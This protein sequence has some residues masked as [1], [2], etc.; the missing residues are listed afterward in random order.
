[1][2]LGCAIITTPGFTQDTQVDSLLAIL[3]ISVDDTSKVNTLND[4][5]SE[6]YRNEPEEAVKYGNMAK[7]L[8]EKLDF[9]KGLARALN[10]IGLG[11]YMQ[12]NYVEASINWAESL[13]IYESIQDQIG[14]TAMLSNLGAVFSMQGD[15]AKAIEYIL[16]SLKISEDSGDSL[17]MATCLLNI[18]AIYSF[19][20]ETRDKALPYYI[21]ALTMCESIN[22]MDGIALSASNL[23][24]YY[25][26]K[27]VYDS[28]LLYLEKSIDVTENEIDK[29]S[30]LDNI[31]KVYADKGDFQSALKYQKEGYEIAEN[32]NAK[33]EMT[34]SLVS[35]GSTY[36]QMGNFEM[37]IKYYQKALT[38][39]IE[40]G[41]NYE[42]MYAY[43]GLALSYSSLSDFRS[44]YK[45]QKLLSSI[46]DSIYNV[47][48]DDKIKSLQ[49]TYQLE[50]KEDEIEILEKNSEIEQLKTK[51]QRIVSL[52][53]GSVG[54]LLLVLAIVIY[55]RFIFTR[56]TKKIIEK[57]R[58]RSDELLL[59]IL[60]SETAE[61]L[62]MNGE[63]KAKSY[64][65]VTVLFTDFKGFTSIAAKMSPEELVEEVNNCY[66]QFDYIITK[67]GIEKI[68]TIGDAYMAAGGLP[69]PNE[70]HA[71]DVLNA[72]IEINDYMLKLKSERE[73]ENRLFF[74]I[75]IGI[76]SGPVVAGIVGIKK[77]AYD[78]WGDTV[79]IAARMETNS[80][81]SKIN[82]SETTYKLVKNYFE[83]SYR[84]EIEAKNRGK[85]KMYY[86]EDKIDV[87]PEVLSDIIS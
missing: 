2:F 19:K 87:K 9:Q 28:A 22:Y 84:G 45:Y 17:R 56:R 31:G 15:E 39:G 66:Q 69:V 47:E 16:R 80:E 58:D 54:I 29:A 68:K 86:V 79:N 82:I 4:L 70:T 62:K 55:R 12:G 32:K 75:R 25:I 23:G 11:Y 60:P 83:C 43:K 65:M 3:E 21:Q 5:C 8:S 6:I 48:T 52:A 41:A 10:Y 37:A 40:I 77:F 13:L 50:K 61:E 42:V 38:V 30:V 1:V 73:V 34:V 57:E 53:S 78:I 49:F 36:K 85:M 63:A 33:F 18:G 27:G 46:K 72:A 76:H 44:A 64:D 51:R 35:L 74:E 59:N 24:A 71:L 14:S 81:V 7:D 20:A 26:S 67:C